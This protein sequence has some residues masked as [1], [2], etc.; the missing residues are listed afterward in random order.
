MLHVLPKKLF[1]SLTSSN[2]VDM[3]TKHRFLEE[4]EVSVISKKQDSRVVFT[5]LIHLRKFRELQKLCLETV[6]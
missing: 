1:P 4:V 2:P 5:L 3:L 6:L